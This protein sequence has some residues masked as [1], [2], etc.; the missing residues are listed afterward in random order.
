MTQLETTYLFESPF[1]KEKFP[2]VKKRSNAALKAL[3]KD[4]LP[5]DKAMSLSVVLADDAFVQDLNKR[6]RGK[7]KPTNVLSFAE[8]TTKA[9]L[10]AA[11]RYGDEPLHIGDLILAYETV[12]REAIE[13]G[14]PLAD[15]TLHMLVH[16]GY[17]L[18]GYDHLQDDEAEAMENK[19]ILLLASLGI[20]NP[21][22]SR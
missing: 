15:H 19:E 22:Q 20:A 2:E 21:Y 17:H 11:P 8:F 18:L 4:E 12:A 1:W 10:L 14:K 13:Q 5:G 6:Y 9:Q 16:G 3:L 7:D